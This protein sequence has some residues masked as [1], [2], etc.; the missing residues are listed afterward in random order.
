MATP[1]HGRTNLAQRL[2]GRT[3]YRSG[4]QTRR[5]TI[6]NRS[7]AFKKM[8]DELTVRSP[9]SF[10]IPVESWHGYRLFLNI[11]CSRF[12]RCRASHIDAIRWKR[13]QPLSQAE[14]R[15]T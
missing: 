2:R 1:Q 4:A 9:D 15:Q 3:F 10:G 13:C 11:L 8:F 12:V 14:F 5:S 7:A 6:V